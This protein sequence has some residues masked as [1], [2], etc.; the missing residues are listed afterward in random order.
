MGALLE[1]R[2]AL[3]LSDHPYQD[4]ETIARGVQARTERVRETLR[5]D[6][7][8]SVMADGRRVYRLG[9]SVWDRQGRADSGIET[10]AAFLLRV[11]SDGKP[12]SLNE[13]LRRSFADRGCGLTTH[14][15]VADLRKLGYRIENTRRRGAHRGEASVYRLVTSVSPSV[16]AS[17]DG[18]TG[19]PGAGRS[20]A[21][22]EGGSQSV[23][24]VKAR[25]R[26][27]DPPGSWTG[28]HAPSLLPEAPETQ[29][30]LGEVA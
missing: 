16:S 3:F 29:L 10:D 23:G 24:E 7:F 13:I 1:D 21:S 20:N 14:S 8:T 11:L 4:L 9:S 18:D 30:T 28:E 17:A 12:H 2:I 19:A 25:L 6:L 22:G 26:S 5:G 27:A 15:R